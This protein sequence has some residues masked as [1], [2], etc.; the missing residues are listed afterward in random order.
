[1]LEVIDKVK[2]KYLEE[3]VLFDLYAGKGIP[4]GMKS[5]ALRMRYRSG[6]KTLADEEI[7]SMH[8]KIIKA[9]HKNLGAEIR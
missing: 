2:V 5:L 6:D 3:V 9:L 7:N 8:A 4:E 1:M